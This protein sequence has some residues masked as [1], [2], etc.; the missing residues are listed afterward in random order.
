MDAACVAFWNSQMPC[1]LNAHPGPKVQVGVRGSGP[2]L[3]YSSR[4]PTQVKV[5]ICEDDPHALSCWSTIA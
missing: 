4:R 1:A 2:L 3:M 5:S